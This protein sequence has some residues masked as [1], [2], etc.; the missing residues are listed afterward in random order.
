VTQSTFVSLVS[1]A[2]FTGVVHT[3]LGPDHYVPFVT[4]ARVGR[5]PLRKTLAVTAVCGAA[6][7]LSSVVLGIIGVATGLA[8]QRLDAL[9][10]ARGRLAAWL[11]IG[12]GIAYF[13]WGFRRAIRHRPHSHW[14]AHPDGTVHCH[15]H[16]H[17]REHAHVHAD[18][19]R[20]RL[21][22]WAL[23]TIFILGPCE[24]L[25][26][27]LMVPAALGRWW[28]LGIVVSAFGAATIG[29]MVGAVMLGCQGLSRISFARW[30]RY[31]HAATGLAIA[32]CGGAMQMGL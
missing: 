14:H 25:I 27:Q 17:T 30:E 9:E 4:L 26:P 3:L 10:A 6:H 22:S 11:L 1:L 7:V 15:G 24:P 12:F 21:S 19:E 18:A 5:W 8:V 31:A 23:F 16:V 28:E 20:Q 2:I 32:A 13:A 29:T